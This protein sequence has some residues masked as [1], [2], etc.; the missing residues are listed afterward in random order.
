[1]ARSRNTQESQ[2]RAFS[3]GFSCILPHSRPSLTKMAVRTLYVNRFSKFFQILNQNNI[4][5][6][7]RGVLGLYENITFFAL[8]IALPHRVAIFND[9]QNDL[10]GVKKIEPHNFW[11]DG[12]LEVPNQS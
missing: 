7:S 12:P 4:L 11:L 9:P 2:K 1:M 8:S 3:L 6:Q 5:H 10:N